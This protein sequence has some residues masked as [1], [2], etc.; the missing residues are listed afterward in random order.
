M[1][2]LSVNSHNESLSKITI[3][4]KVKSHLMKMYV[5]NMT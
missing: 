1:L 4:G 2:L 5:I 3:L